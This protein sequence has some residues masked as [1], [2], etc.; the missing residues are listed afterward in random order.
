MSVIGRV[1][2][3][4]YNFTE[5]IGRGGEATVYRHPADQTLAGR[6]YHDSKRIDL[7]RIQH[8]LGNEPQPSVET[9]FP[10]FGWPVDIITDPSTGHLL[11]TVV[12]YAPHAVP[13][14]LVMNPGYRLK[15]ISPEWLTHVARSLAYRAYSAAWQDYLIADWNPE[16]FL[17]SRHGHVCAVD[18]E[19]YQFTLANGKTNPCGVGLPEYMAPEQLSASGAPKAT[20]ETVVWS[21]MVHV[22]MLLRGGEHPFASANTSPRLVERIRQGLWPDSGKFVAYQP[23]RGAQPFNQIPADIQSLCRRTFGEGHGDPSLRP[24]PGEI[25]QAI[26]KLGITR[27]AISQSAWMTQFPSAPPKRCPLFKKPGAIRP[28]APVAVCPRPQLRP[29]HRTRYIAAASLLCVLLAAAITWNQPDKDQYN[30]LQRDSVTSSDPVHSH[31]PQTNLPTPVLWRTLR[32]S[33]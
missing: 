11:G 14:S 33:P 12:R 26:D 13:L 4:T 30:E 27:V 8:M 20:R 3:R 7:A 28:A 22:H 32:E 17:V 25:V 5:V 16:N 15:E 23:P 6:F 10:C 9:G 24:S 2:N 29:R 31:L 18:C 21:L 1:G 19:A